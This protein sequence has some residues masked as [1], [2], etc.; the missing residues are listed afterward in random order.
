MGREVILHRTD[1][2]AY[3]RPVVRGPSTCVIMAEHPDF[4]SPWCQ[5]LLASPSTSDIR[6]FAVAPQRRDT[7][8][9]LFRQTLYNGKAIKAYVCFRRPGQNSNALGG[10]EE[11]DLIS[12]GPGV[13]GKSGRAHGGFS[14]L[15]LD[16]VTGNCASFHAGHPGPNSIPPA[17]ARLEVDY[18]APL[19]TPC[20]VLA[21]AWATKKERRK[22]WIKGV[23]EDGQGE[24]L[25]S[26]EALFITG[27]PESK[28]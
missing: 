16:Q 7:S 21:R 10:V 24:V 11:C 1:R 17:T 25:A 28:L 8:H 3:N 9:A 20:V 14:A 6:D 4:K 26:C 18:K 2:L 15:V 23:I 13:D 22:I 5:H 19:S 12:V 27:R